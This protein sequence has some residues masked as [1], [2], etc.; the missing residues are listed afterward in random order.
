MHGWENIK[1]YYL[2]SSFL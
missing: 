2:Q 1:F